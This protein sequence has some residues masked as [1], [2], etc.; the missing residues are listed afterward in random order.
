M[1]SVAYYLKILRDKKIPVLWRPYH[2][3]NGGW[4][5]WGS[6]PG[7]DGYQKLWKMLYERYTNY[8]KLNNLIWVWNANA[9]RVK[10]NDNAMAYENFYPGN[11]YVDI[12]AADIYNSDYKQ[13]HHDQLVELGK[14]KL[15]AMGE[16]GDVPSP[17]ILK[18]QPQW[19][20]FMVWARFPWTKNTPEEMN[21]FYNAPSVISLDE[22]RS[23]K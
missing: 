15:I 7:P 1:D 9:P 21:A 3:M 4:F 23:K 17:E 11:E 18:Q 22:V 5:W 2:E 10:Q 8:H 20:W 6:R 13:S 12:L 16:I 19:S 14:G